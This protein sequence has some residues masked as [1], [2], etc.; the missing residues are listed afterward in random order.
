MRSPKGIDPLSVAADGGDVAW[1]ARLLQPGVSPSSPGGDVSPVERATLYGHAGVVRAL[2]PKEGKEKEEFA[3]VVGVKALHI[4]ACEGH[5]NVVSVLLNEGGVSV[6]AVREGGLEK[7]AL[8]YA[9]SAGQAEV[10]ELL[11]NKGANGNRVDGTGRTPVHHAAW[12]KDIS[13]SAAIR[14][15]DALLSGGK[16][17][18]NATDGY[19]DTPLHY[20]FLNGRLEVASRLIRWGAD[21]TAVNKGGRTPR[22]LAAVR[23]PRPRTVTRVK[24]FELI[25][26][27]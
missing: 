16:V 7:T 26:R 2:I 12:Q 11:M 20:A 9:S 21:G 14:T 17:N 18:V 22:E 25:P 10:V 27:R 4:A 23:G 19:R 3:R 13:A 24:E 1:V 15:L 6:D 5:L 8:H